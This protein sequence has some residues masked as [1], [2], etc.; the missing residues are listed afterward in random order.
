[1]ELNLKK[2]STKICVQINLKIWKNNFV[3]EKIE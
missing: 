2:K 1:M 3:N